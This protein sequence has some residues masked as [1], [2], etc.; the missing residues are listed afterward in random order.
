MLKNFIPVGNGYRNTVIGC[1]NGSTRCT[2]QEGIPKPLGES[3]FYNTCIEG[4]WSGVV[5]VDNGLS[6]VGDVLIESSFCEQ[7]PIIQQCSFTGIR[8]L[9][10]E[11]ILLDNICTSRYLEC[12][13]GQLSNPISL[14]GTPHTKE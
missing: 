7:P 12:V 8:C 5:P 2:T 3:C 10:D 14:P 13:D 4:K 6:C 11:G 1:A 9:G